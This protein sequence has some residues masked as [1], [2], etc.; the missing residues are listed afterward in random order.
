MEEARR[1]ITAALREEGLP[2]H[3]EEWGQV[4]AAD[5][6]TFGSPTVIVDGR[7]VAS[8]EVVRRTESGSR[9]RVYTDGNRMR[10]APSR[11][12]IRKALRSWKQ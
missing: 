9:C 2:E 4:V 7:D 11:E 1:E 12:T 6:Q 10:G 5:E 3:W 8:G